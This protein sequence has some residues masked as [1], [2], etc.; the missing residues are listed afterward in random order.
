MTSVSCS[1]HAH[2]YASASRDG[3]IAPRARLVVSPLLVA[4][5]LA[6]ALVAVAPLQAQRADSTS[7]D[8]TRV[9][10]TIEVRGSAT[11][12][13]QV[14][15]G[16]AISKLDVQLAPSGTSPLKAI[17][18]LP[19]VNM[20]GADPFGLYEW[21]TRITMRGFQSSQV[22]Q[23]FDGI[24]LGDMS[25]GNFNGL[26]VGRAVDSDNLSDATV[27]QGGSALGTA[28]SNNLGGVVQY[29][30][31]DP[32]N[33]RGLS[34]RQMV[35]ASSARRSALKFETG[36]LSSGSTA[37]KSY[38]SFSRYD[39]DKWKGSGERFSPAR[40]GLFAQNGLVGGAGEQWMDQVNWKAQ[41][42]RGAHKFTA[43]Y[44]FADKKE[45]D[46]T[47][48]TLARFNQSG[49]DWD[50]F[51]SWDA[52]KVAA[53]SSNPDQAYFHS[54]QGARRDHLAYLSAD[55]Q[56]NDRAL[57]SLKP[58]LHTNVGAGDWHAPNYGSTAFSPDP[59]YFRQTIYDTRRMGVLARGRFQ[60]AGNDLEVG[61]WLEQ[62]EANITRKAWRMK[63]YASS[64][65][66]DFSNVLAQ[67]FDRTGDISTRTL[68]V[69]NTNTF[70]GE[71]LKVSYGVKYLSIGADFT[72]NGKTDAAAKLF[73]DP[74]RP[75]VS[76]PTDGGL[77]PQVG[78][79]WSADRDWQF[80]GNF[81]QNVNAY[82]YS[83][84]SGVY[85]TNAT[86]FDFF[87]DNTKPEKA[88][89]I[90]GGVRMRKERVEASLGLYTIDYNN[91]LI[92][93]AVCPLTA[94]CVSSF[95]NVGGVSTRGAEALL[96]FRLADGL[97]WVNSAAFNDSKIDNDYKSGT[98]T[99]ASSGK[100]VVDAPKVLANSS[101]RLTRG[102][103]LGSLSA[104]H[105]GKRYFSILNDIAAPSYTTL[106]M[107]AGYTFKRV[108][109][110]KGLSIQMSAMNLLD[111]K[112]IATVGTGGFSVS[113][114]LETLMAGSKRLVFLT[115]GTS[116]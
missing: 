50:Q 85:N 110:L 53:T 24:T 114:D 42:L 32:S 92:G 63:N 103:V 87:K 41:L 16:N 109:A 90:E 30:S 20:Q 80:F 40:S 21:A 9:L 10:R 71:R 18:R 72:N 66:V 105:V 74:T 29:T 38:L 15:A 14:R 47:D 76:I 97:S 95:A 62:N 73:G 1:P 77:L 101:L 94:T 37:F 59:I 2:E 116:F 89:T 25:Y 112:Y 3:A 45:S 44:N 39:T 13:G 4:R 33:T 28:S 26:N 58:Y 70:A 86:A 100:T 107:S 43:Y 8:S 52:A 17:E 84:Q 108:G 79:V 88:T 35:G 5:A 22:G 104:R 49:R 55:F 46:Y 93:V 57:V 12:L 7:R 34:L 6:L 51:A 31:A 11:G 61:G 68:Y 102:G 65:V 113:G 54:A 19:G 56:L 67:F 83:P 48:L 106:D 96:S 115:V 78:L 111:E 81:S 23:T 60:F 36:L 69:Q 64:P 27:T 99:V 98:T 91:R 82:P 75:N